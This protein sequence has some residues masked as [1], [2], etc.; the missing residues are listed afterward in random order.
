[1]NSN[2]RMIN[3]YLNISLILRTHLNICVLPVEGF[4]FEVKL[5]PKALWR[6]KNDL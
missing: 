3:M 1:M 4:G 2:Q 5:T 6:P